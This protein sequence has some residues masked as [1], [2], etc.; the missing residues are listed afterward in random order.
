MRR[1]FIDPDGTQKDYFGVIV[2]HA[3]GVVYV[4][5]CGC[6]STQEREAE[7]YFV[8]VFPGG[9]GD[10]AG[11]RFPADLTALFHKD[12]IG[13]STGITADKKIRLAEILEKIP[14]WDLDEKQTHLR[15][16]EERLSDAIEAWVPILTPDG[17]GI[18]TW[19]N[20][21]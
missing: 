1:I 9:A 5:Q 15:L 12:G 21:D 6:T 14:W 3:T 20:C 13:N 18:L 17:P 10:G 16:D 11:S 8:P 7:G 19:P 2:R 4:Q